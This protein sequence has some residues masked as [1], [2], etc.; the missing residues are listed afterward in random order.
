MLRLILKF[1]IFRSSFYRSSSPGSF[2]WHWGG[3][4]WKTLMQ[5]LLL[6][7]F[8]KIALLAVVTMIL[9]CLTDL[10]ITLKGLEDF[11]HSWLWLT[12][13]QNELFMFHLTRKNAFNLFQVPRKYPECH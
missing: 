6:L 4:R 5:V 13:I 3:I 11:S 7:A 8:H 9:Q 10:Q 12:L 1:A 2:S